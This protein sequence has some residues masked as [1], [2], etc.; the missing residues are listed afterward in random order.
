M[1][2]SRVHHSYLRSSCHSSPSSFLA[3]VTQ[4]LGRNDFPILHTEKEITSAFAEA[5]RIKLSATLSTE[6]CRGVGCS[7]ETTGAD[8]A[9]CSLKGE[10]LTGIFNI[11]EKTSP[12]GYFLFQRIYNVNH[13]IHMDRIVW[14]KVQILYPDKSNL[15]Q[16]CQLS[17]SLQLL[18]GM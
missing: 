12:T 3:E 7:R 17:F 13:I 16:N 8:S 9:H 18:E 2:H 4:K 1:C 6:E 15:G 10:R 11:T 14:Q 5:S